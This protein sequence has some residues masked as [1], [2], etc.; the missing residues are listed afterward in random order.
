MKVYIHKVSKILLTWWVWKN[1]GEVYSTPVLHCLHGIK[2][3]LRKLSVKCSLVIYIPCKL[4]LIYQE[5]GDSAC[6]NHNEITRQRGQ[7]NTIGVGL[8]RT[9]LCYN[10]TRFFVCTILRKRELFW[11]VSS[12]THS[13]ILKCISSLPTEH[14]SMIVGAMDYWNGSLSHI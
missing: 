7:I 4:V 13:V 8:L 11:I 10:F 2:G 5:C 6:R 14:F 3:T 12:Q 1:F 9:R